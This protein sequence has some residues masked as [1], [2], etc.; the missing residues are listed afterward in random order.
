M[1]PEALAEVHASAFDPPWDAATFATL[2]GQPGVLAL[3]DDDGFILIRV[4]LDEAEILTLA[5]RPE[6]RRRGR[7]R[8]LVASAG[9]LARSLGADR[10]YLEVAQ[11]NGAAQALYVAGGFVEVGRRPGYYSRP[12]GPAVAALLLARNLAD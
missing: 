12:T 10:L 4:V 1:T 3:G 8:G 9:R 2:L 6:A 7:G 11:D 5:V